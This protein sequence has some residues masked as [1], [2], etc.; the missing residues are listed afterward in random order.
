MSESK[1][2]V[3]AVSRPKLR[4]KTCFVLQATAASKAAPAKPADDGKLVMDSAAIAR[5]VANGTLSQ[6]EAAK[7]T[8]AQLEFLVRKRLSPGSVASPPRKMVRERMIQLQNGGSGKG[9]GVEGAEWS[10][11][12]NSLGAP[13]QDDGQRRVGK[14][15]PGRLS[16]YLGC[17]GESSDCYAGPRPRSVYIRLAL[18]CITRAA[19]A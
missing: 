2:V 19:V 1:P 17:S 14:E 15:Y 12:L 10:R 16:C 7:F 4:S 6:E 13:G 11:L 9:A 5:Y 8:P 18:V 3:S